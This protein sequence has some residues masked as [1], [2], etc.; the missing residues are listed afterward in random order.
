MLRNFTIG[1]YC[2]VQDDMAATTHTCVKPSAS[3]QTR[4]HTLSP[5]HSQMPLSDASTVGI[6]S[7]LFALHDSLTT[8]STAPPSEAP[9]AELNRSLPPPHSDILVTPLPRPIAAFELSTQREVAFLSN[10]N[11]SESMTTDVSAHSILPLRRAQ[12]ASHRLDTAGSAIWC[13]KSS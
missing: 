1:K 9:A 7:L 2:V 3:R 10:W 5:T 11:L 8:T 13:S 4:L 6:K 12:G